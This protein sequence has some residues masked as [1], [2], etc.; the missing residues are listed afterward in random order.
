MKLR[1]YNQKTT[2]SSTKNNVRNEK[3]NDVKTIK[4]R[5]FHLKKKYDEGT[6][7]Y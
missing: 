1:E 5:R 3:T 4:K 7:I 6:F 2:N